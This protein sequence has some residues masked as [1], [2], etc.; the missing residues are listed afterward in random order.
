MKEIIDEIPETELPGER[1]VLRVLHEPDAAGLYRLIDASRE[2]LSRFLPWPPDCNSVEYVMDRL[3]TWVMQAQ[4]GNGTCWGIFEKTAGGDNLAGC[5]FI[6]W[7]HPEHRSATISY[8]LGQ[9]FTGRGLATEALNLLCKFCFE[10]LKLNRLEITAAVENK[11]SVYSV[12]NTLKGG[13]NIY[14]KIEIEDPLKPNYNMERDEL[15]WAYYNMSGDI[16]I[17]SLPSVT[18]ADNGKTLM[19][20]NGVWTLVSPSTIYVGTGTPSSQ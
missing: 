13:I 8:W 4:M 7:V 19:V 18:A 10:A 12:A 5:I 20:V 17:A 2:H 15:C 11:A 14:K 9:N 3:E 16:T 6:G 1:V